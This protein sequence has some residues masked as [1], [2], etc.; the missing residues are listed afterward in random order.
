MLSSAAKLHHHKALGT[1]VTN[2]KLNREHLS[3][4]LRPLVVGYFNQ[5]GMQLQVNCV[6]KEDM[7]DAQI[8]PNLHKNLIVRVGGYAEY[9]NYLTPVLQQDVI[10]RIEH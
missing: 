4:T 1:V 2:I 5:G 6:S 10:S 3:K 8:N 7:L 9:F